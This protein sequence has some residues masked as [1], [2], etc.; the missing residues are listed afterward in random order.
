MI[1]PREILQ[2]VGRVLEYHQG[3]KLTFDDFHQPMPVVD[4]A[5]RPS[6][7]RIFSDHPKT[8]LPTRLLDA[9]AGTLA[10]MEASLEALPDSWVAPPQDL[11]TLASWL[12]MAAGRILVQEGGQISWRRACPSSG[13]AYPCEIYVAAFGVRDLEPGLYH[14]SSREFS[15]RKLREGSETLT[16]IKRGR[17]DLEFLKTAPAAILVSTIFCRTAWQEGERA[18][19][20]AL[21]DAG[22]LVQN[23]VTAG[24]GLGIQTITRLR[25]HDVSM[26]ELIGLPVDMGFGE[27]ESVQ[28]MV[29]WADRATN[30]LAMPSRP[31]VD[32]RGGEG[33]MANP[34]LKDRAHLP[35]RVERRRRIQFSRPAHSRAAICKPRRSHLRRARFDLPSCSSSPGSLLRN[36]SPLTWR[37]WQRTRI[38]WRRASRCVMFGRR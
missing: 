5:T 3:A 22:H 15:L 27:A 23:L 20:T 14:F 32:W 4:P 18:Y 30:P 34:G 36:T 26:R 33:E 38:V 29:V 7:D 2:R 16:Q 21:L 28:S 12:H 1:L 9:S 6:A 37:S 8:P 24:S 25:V 17:P 11:K 31:A 10:V 13:A 35:C 19:R